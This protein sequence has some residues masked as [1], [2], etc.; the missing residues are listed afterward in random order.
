MNMTLFD[1]VKIQERINR[2]K[3]V[4]F[5]EGLKQI[6]EIGFDRYP[7]PDEILP[8][9]LDG[10]E[11]K[12]QK[13]SKQKELF[14]F[15]TTNADIKQ[16][17]RLPRRNITQEWL[18]LAIQRKS[19]TPSTIIV[20]VDPEGIIRD[21]QENNIILP[22]YRIGKQFRYAYKKEFEIKKIYG[23][24]LDEDDEDDEDYY[25]TETDSEKCRID[26]LNM[27]NKDFIKF[28]FKKEGAQFPAGINVGYFWLPGTCCKGIYPVQYA[29]QTAMTWN[30]ICEPSI[31]FFTANTTLVETAYAR[32]IKTIKQEALK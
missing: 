18:S 20:Y 32:G 3:P 14:K 24:V 6:R 30:G 19:G 21:S 2:N 13:N 7:R 1:K 29:L 17:E 12:L 25:T 27:G 4:Y 28:L 11:E 15:V 22:K 9:I 26:I 23:L 5:D 31:D 16:Y 8:L 10:L